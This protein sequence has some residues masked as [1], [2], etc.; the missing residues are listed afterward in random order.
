MGYTHHHRDKVI[1]KPDA[2]ACLRKNED[3]EQVMEAIEPLKSM[4]YLKV[5]SVK[6]RNKVTGEIVS[7]G[8]V[9]VIVLD[10]FCSLY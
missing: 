4:D 5:V 2:P 3:W 10:G 9:S 6:F 1:K 8:L 7:V